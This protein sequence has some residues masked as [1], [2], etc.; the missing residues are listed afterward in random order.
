MKMEINSKGVM[1]LVLGITVLMVFA[2]GL[3]SCSNDDDDDKFGNWVDRSIFDGTPRSGAAAFTIGNKGYMGTG[4]DGDDRLTDFWVYDMDGNFWSQ[5]AS[6]P[7]VERSSTASFTINGNGYV[8]LGFDG[9]NELA[10]FYRYNVSSNLWDSIAPFGGNA[11]R[12]AT[13]FNSETNGYVGTGFD[14]DN[15][16]KDFWKY[17]PSDDT[18]AELVGFGGNK[19]RDASVFSIGENVYLGTGVSNGLNQT[20]FWVFNLSSE[21]WSPLLDLDDDDDY[22]IVRNN[23]VGFSIGD[24]GYFATGDSG[25]SASVDVWEYDPA[26]DLWEEKTE[27]EGFARQGAIAF[28]NGARAFLGLGRSGTL[29]L[30]DNREF[31]PN[32][33]EDEDD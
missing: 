18:W 24:K 33:E 22:N 6:F 23:A 9:D 20:D 14:G 29:Y 4:F 13:A 15:D 2:I 25:S 19:R 32:Q 12:G 10:D 28:Y 11:R 27:Y 21:S 3:A 7:G 17:N 1:K 8:G 5:L 31:F 26:T 30:D 16:R